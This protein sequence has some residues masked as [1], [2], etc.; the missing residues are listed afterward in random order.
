MTDPIPLKTATK[1]T[2]KFKYNNH[3]AMKV[4]SSALLKKYR[5]VANERAHFKRRI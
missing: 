1:D 2:L 4:F 5:E 3:L